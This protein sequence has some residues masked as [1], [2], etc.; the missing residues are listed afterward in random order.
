MPT[1]SSRAIHIPTVGY[2]QLPVP[3]PA[4]HAREGITSSRQSVLSP[5]RSGAQHALWH[6]REVKHLSGHSGIAGCDQNQVRVVVG[7]VWLLPHHPQGP[8]QAADPKSTMRMMTT[9]GR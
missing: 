9:L 3:V 6:R 7:F 8:L 5:S 2:P 4:S 1:T